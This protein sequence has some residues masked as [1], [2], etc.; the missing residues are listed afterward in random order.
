[1]EGAI[2]LLLF[3]LYQSKY[4]NNF[5]E[6]F[7]GSINDGKFLSNLIR[8]FIELF[9]KIENNQNMLTFYY[10]FKIRCI[11]GN[12]ISLRCLITKFKQFYLQC[13]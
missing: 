13:F 4:F 9:I 1:M 6:L 8:H 12:F 11:F 7:E 5:F 2:L 10:Q 3:T